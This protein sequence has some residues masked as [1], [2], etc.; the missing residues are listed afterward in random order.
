ME[1]VPKQVKLRKY[2]EQTEY[3]KRVKQLIQKVNFIAEDPEIF[4]TLEEDL[5]Y[6]FTVYKKN[7]KKLSIKQDSLL[8]SL[9]PDN[10]KDNLKRL[11]K[12]YSKHSP[13]EYINISKSEILNEIM[14]IFEID[15]VREKMIDNH[16]KYLKPDLANLLKKSLAVNFPEEDK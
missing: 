6:I 16:I 1:I 7:I 3:A 11:I 8:S 13:R 14:E 2:D 10:K 12:K 5:Q 9:N 4:E 15:I